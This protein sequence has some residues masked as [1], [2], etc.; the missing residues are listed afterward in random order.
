MA[1]W[2]CIFLLGV[3]PVVFG[4][5]AELDRLV[6][7]STRLRAM[8]P[9]G[10]YPWDHFGKVRRPE[11]TNLKHLLRDWIESRLPAN[12][13]ALDREYRGLEAQLK[14]EL[15]RAGVLEP[16]KPAARAGYVSSVKLSRAAD[17]PG[18]LL[19]RLA[20]RPIRL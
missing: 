16:E 13:P 9:A 18:A 19:V 6:A 2:S 17:Y 8:T 7:E 5:Q 12:L 4:Q 20:L 14:A 1:K 15:E 3:A 10:E 11:W